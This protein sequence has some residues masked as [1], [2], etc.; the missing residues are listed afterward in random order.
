MAKIEIYANKTATLSMVKSL[1][2]VERNTLDTETMK[3]IFIK[4]K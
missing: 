3:K 2:L 1:K 4:M